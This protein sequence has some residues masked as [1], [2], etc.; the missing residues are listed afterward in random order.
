MADGCMA[1]ANGYAPIPSSV[2]VGNG[3][4]GEQ[5][6]G[7]GAYRV[8]DDIY[9]FA[10]TETQIKRFQPSGYTTVGTGYASVPEI[11]VRFVS[12]NTFMLATNGIDLIQRFDPVGGAFADIATAP[13]ARFIATVRGFAVA[14]Y[15]DDD[16]R[17]IAWSDNGDPGTW[18]PGTGDAGFAIMA[19]GG[20]ITGIVGGEYGLVFQENRVVRMT[21]TGDD[22]VWQFDE[23]ATD[24]G[25][26]APKSIATYGRQTY[27]LSNTGL[28][29][30]DGVSVRGVG[31]EK[32]DRTFLSLADRSYFQDMSAAIDPRN[33]LYL[34]AVPSARPTT[35][36]FIFNFALERWSTAP[37][38]TKLL[39]SGLAQ[40]VTLEDLDAIYTYLDTMPL[41]LDSVAFRGGFPLLQLFDGS[42]R[43]AAL[44]GGNLPATFTDA[45]REYFEGQKARIRVIRPF[46][47][48]PVVDVTLSVSNSLSTTTAPNDFTARTT[49]GVYR[50]R[51]VGNY[52]QTTIAIPA[53]T[54]W[55]FCQGYDV[56]AVP[57][58][59]A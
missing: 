5:P 33:S 35:S 50:T 16:S 53:G 37:I 12:Y 48:A 40:G 3:G 11:Q 39:F 2:P 27:F 42:N 4:L 36:V 51:A 15:T 26:I 49:S 13:V 59:R 21:A 43:L 45:L 23:I 52:A 22:L 32:V 29:V 9:V 19:T 1:I 30:C 25:C 44:S 54:V 18:T 56:D 8:A 7:A 10:A 31:T 57:G 6:Y 28:M 58:G 14:A 34:V 20:D 38:T 47:D 46:T 24:V 41:S 55:T 17:Q